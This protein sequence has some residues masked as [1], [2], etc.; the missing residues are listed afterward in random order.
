MVLLS[1]EGCR[2]SP[3]LFPTATPTLESNDILIGNF[4]KE[5]ARRAQLEFS[6]SKDLTTM[7]AE[8]RMSSESKS[9]NQRTS[10]HPT[11]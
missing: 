11:P 2:Q 9:P 10:R 6:R 8:Q 4:E 7:M 3:A 1:C 5:G